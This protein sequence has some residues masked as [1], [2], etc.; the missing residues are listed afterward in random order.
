MVRRKP[1]ISVE[2]SIKRGLFVLA[3]WHWE[4][5]RREY[6]RG[7]GQGRVERAP[8][9]THTELKLMATARRLLPLS[10]CFC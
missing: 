9:R 1:A 7:S 10:L 2:Q 3:S 8:Q 5:T 6:K 4:G